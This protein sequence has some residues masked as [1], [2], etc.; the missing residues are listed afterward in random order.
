MRD[1]S[2]L[3]VN[4]RFHDIKF[5]VSDTV[6][7]LQQ[8]SSLCAVQEGVLGP[9]AVKYYQCSQGG[10]LL[11]NWSKLFMIGQYVQLRMYRDSSESSVI[12]VYEI[13]VHGY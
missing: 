1:K 8:G 7:N 11:E 10:F 4:R 12:H 2:I 13:E 6:D 3:D 9:G 5:E